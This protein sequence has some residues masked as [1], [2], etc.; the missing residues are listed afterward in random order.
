MMGFALHWVCFARLFN[1]VRSGAIDSDAFSTKLQEKTNVEL[2]SVIFKSNQ[3]KECPV[4]FYATN[5]VIVFYWNTF[6]ALSSGK[7]HQ[8]CC[9]HW[10]PNADLVHQN[11]KKQVKPGSWPGSNYIV[12][13]YKESCDSLVFFLSIFIWG[14]DLFVGNDLFSVKNK[15]KIFSKQLSKI[16]LACIKSNP[17]AANWRLLFSLKSILHISN[18]I[19]HIFRLISHHFLWH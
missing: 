14:F 6:M 12:L 19:P 17:K 18:P 10:Q 9:S 11:P 3:Q 2:F 4:R 1:C 15:M 8:L 5:V 16:V 13:R 7:G